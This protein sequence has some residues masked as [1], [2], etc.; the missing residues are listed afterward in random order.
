M[1]DGQELQSVKG[2]LSKWTNYIHG[3]QQRYFELQDGVLVYYKSEYDT[4]FGCRGSVTIGKAIIEVRSDCLFVLINY[5]CV[6]LSN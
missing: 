3:W 1:S 6:I 4:S 2:T 5:A